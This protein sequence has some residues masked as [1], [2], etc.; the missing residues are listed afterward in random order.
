MLFLFQGD[1]ITDC[2][3]S[4]LKPTDLG[5]GYVNLINHYLTTHLAHLN[6]TCL[7]KG[8]YGNRTHNLCRRWE[9]DCLDQNPDLL[10]ILIGINDTWRRFDLHL[11]T[12]PEEFRSNYM[13]LL[14]SVRARH[15][16]V[17]LVLMSPFLLP[18]EVHQ[19]EW[20]ED[21]NQKIKIIKEL[22]AA[23]QAIY[24]P[25]HE[26]FHAHITPEKPNIY[27]TNDGV[28]PNPE[29]HILIAKTW[30]KAVLEPYLAELEGIRHE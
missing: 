14:D 23:Y 26:V 29:G 4:R 12:T 21:L 24:I 22:A 15:P 28:H 30:I 18:V 11:V 10:S 8:I 16:H 5:E 7:N 6:I 9:R 3:R 1:S 13:Y 2:S 25:L 27:W 19:L 17:K 20:F